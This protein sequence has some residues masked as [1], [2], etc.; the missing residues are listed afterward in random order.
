MGGPFLDEGHAESLAL[1]PHGLWP[2]TGLY[3]SDVCLVEE[4]EAKTALSDTSSDTEGEFVVQQLLVEEE[5]LALLFASEF[6]L[7]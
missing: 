6:K 1:F 2:D 3:F 7:A 5:V 4:H